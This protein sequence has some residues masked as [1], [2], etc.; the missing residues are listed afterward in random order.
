M[1][2]LQG[3]I[4][5]HRKIQDDPFYPKGREF[6]KYEA[7]L[8]LL[9]LANHTEAEVVIGSSIYKVKRGELI[10]SMTTLSR[11]WKWGRGKV[12]RFLKLLQ[13]RG[14]IDFKTDTQTTHIT[15]CKY[16]TYQGGRTSNEQQTDIKRT[17]NGHKQ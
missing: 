9:L 3:R 4:S 8:D 15:I 17:S 1:S 12:K 10:Y 16:D 2:E 14:T 13:K 5:L 6:S 11:R 7:L